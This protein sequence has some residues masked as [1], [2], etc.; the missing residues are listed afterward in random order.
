M[1]RHTPGPWMVTDSG[2]DVAAVQG[3]S[4]GVRQTLEDET[5]GAGAVTRAPPLLVG[6]RGH[7]HARRGDRPGPCET[8]TD[9]DLDSVTVQRTKDRVEGPLCPPGTT[10]PACADEHAQARQVGGGHGLDPTNTAR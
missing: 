10:E 9:H 5:L 3:T 2:G 6:G 7:P 1:S 4:D 8:L